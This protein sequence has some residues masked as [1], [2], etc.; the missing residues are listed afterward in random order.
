MEPE[1]QNR[2]RLE[3]RASA[4]KWLPCINNKPHS[5]MLYNEHVN[6]LYYTGENTSTPLIA[7]LVA[8][9]K[10]RREEK[11]NEGYIYRVITEDGSE[12]SVVASYFAKMYAQVI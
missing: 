12:Q 7:A 9:R 2:A 6:A 8:E 10:V 4:L 3:I 11:G 5:L 1:P